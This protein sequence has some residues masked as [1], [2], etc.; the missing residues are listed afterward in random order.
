ML[1][2]VGHVQRGMQ[3]SS[4]NFGGGSNAIGVPLMQTLRLTP[5]GKKSIKVI[6]Y[7]NSINGLNKNT[8]VVAYITSM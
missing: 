5:M 4:L 7:K 6:T 8:S 2:I 3:L 1:G